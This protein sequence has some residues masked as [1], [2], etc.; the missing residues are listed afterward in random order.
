MIF[1]TTKSG[2]KITET[3]PEVQAFITKYKVSPEA[4]IGSVISIR[5]K[6][7]AQGG[8]GGTLEGTQ[9][10]ATTQPIAPNSATRS[11]LP[12]EIGNLDRFK[13]AVQQATKIAL[14]RGPSLEATAE[15]F[16]QAGVP[17]FAPESFGQAGGMMGKSRAGAI[18][19]IFTQTVDLI[20]EQEKARTEQQ[21]TNLAFAKSFFSSLPETVLA[22]MDTKEFESIKGGVVPDTLLQKFQVAMESQPTKLDTQ[23]VD[24]G[25]RKVLINAQTGATIKNLGYSDTG[26]GG[27]LSG[28]GSFPIPTAPEQPKETFSQFVSRKQGETGKAYSPTGAELAK[29]K[30]EFNAV[31]VSPTPNAQNQD[32]SRYSFAVRQVILGKEP[33]SALLTGGTAGERKR[34]QAELSD[35]EKR[36]LLTQELSATQQKFISSMNE[37]VSKNT[38]YQKTLSMQTYANNVVQSL[39]LGTGVSDIAAINQFQ[40][41]IDEGAVTRDQDVRLIQGAQSLINTLKTKI[42][43]LEKGEALSPELRQQMRQ[44]TETLYAAQIEALKKD[45][46]I[47]SQIK[48]TESYNVKLDD[49]ILSELGSFQ[50]EQQQS[51]KPPLSSAGSKYENPLTDHIK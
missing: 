31:K 6:Q 13:S 32:L 49:T 42:K 20:K 21:A 36:G 23:V 9:P 41:V 37:K 1:G 29:L 44:A 4:A 2:Q 43:K 51:Q 8:L 34:Y 5:D 26:D 30:D 14:S 11:A 48:E 47:K 18:G 15:Q 45:P 19:D 35:A 39:Q 17:L 16:G 27:G 10:G 46:Y 25:G 28:F 24:V 38:T 7:P 22:Q 3:D 33:A 12:N 40:K 50:T